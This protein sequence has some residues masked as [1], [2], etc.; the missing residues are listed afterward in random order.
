[1]GSRGHQMGASWA[2]TEPN[3]TPSVLRRQYWEITVHGSVAM[4]K[5]HNE[6]MVN[7]DSHF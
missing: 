5:I 7:Y 4:V 3:V 1:M 2:F 6:N